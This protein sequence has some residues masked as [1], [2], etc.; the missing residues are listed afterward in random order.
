M[1][2]RLPGGKKIGMMRA[3]LVLAVASALIASTPLAALA[4]KKTFSRKYPTSRTV[5]ISLKN[6]FGT[7]TVEAWNR[8]EIKI[9]ADMDSPSARIVP[10][11]STDNIE[12][13]VVR[14]NRGKDDAGEVSFRI[15]VPVNSAVDIETRRGNITV[16]G[17]QG[18]MVRAH[19]YTS[20]DI[21]LTGIRASRVI[22]D[23]VSG[24]IF[25]DGELVGGGTYEFKSYKGNI[26][27]R[28]PS[29]SEFRL[30]AVA[31]TSR[32][33]TLG[34]FSDAGLSFYGDGR[35]VTG[36]VGGGRAL[37]TITNYQ[38]SIAFIRR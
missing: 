36:S 16:R 25:F 27:I 7:I 28:I 8:D 2:V 19:I 33:I 13:N 14:D 37:L 10:E 5:R 18:A 11:V 32:S 12:I 30:K 4:Q 23:N 35:Q 21:E 1:K 20:G 6:S 22:A 15:M 38:G 26:N 3:T 34:S 24:D 17:V 31:T 29:D 9:S